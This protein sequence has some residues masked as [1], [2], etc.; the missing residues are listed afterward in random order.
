[1]GPLLFVKSLNVGMFFR[2]STLRAVLMA[3]IGVLPPLRGD[4]LPH[5]ANPLAC[6]QAAIA[7]AAGREGFNKCCT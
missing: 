3:R 5:G 6:L 4:R 1:M 2:K 7:A